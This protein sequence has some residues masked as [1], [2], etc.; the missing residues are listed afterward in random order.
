MALRA[1]RTCP[2]ASSARNTSNPDG[3]DDVHVHNTFHTLAMTLRLEKIRFELFF[4]DVRERKNHYRG[5]QKEEGDEQ[6]QLRHHFR[7][8]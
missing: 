1:F 4:E 2:G 3:F 7:Y 6:S 8:T 5:Y